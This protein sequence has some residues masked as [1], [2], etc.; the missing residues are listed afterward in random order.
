MTHDW[1]QYTPEQVRA[2]KIDGSRLVLAFA[3]D[4][5]NYFNQ[6]LTCINCESSF[7]NE[8]LKYIRTMSKEAKNDYELKPKYNGL[9]LGFGLRGRVYNGKITKKQADHLLKNHPKGKDLSK[10]FRKT[11]Q[12]KCQKKKLSPY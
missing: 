4:Y 6:E 2:D 9:P 3:K 8:F 11:V 12:L 5:K 7:K 1:Q 10:F